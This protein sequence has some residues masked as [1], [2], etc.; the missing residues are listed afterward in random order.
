VAIGVADCLTGIAFCYALP[1][2]KT[3]APSRAINLLKRFEPRNRKH[4]R[5]WLARRHATSTGVW[6]VYRKN[7][8]RQITY[9]EAVEEALCFGWIDSV[10]RPIDETKYMQLFTPR[11]AKSTWSRINKGRIEKL[12]KAGLM[13][14]AGEA[15][16]AIA[17]K[18]GSW[19]SID[20]V[21]A[22]VIPEDLAAAIAANRNATENF[23]KLSPSTRRIYL[24]YINNAKRP[25]TR[26]RHLA[27]VVAL[28]AERTTLP[29]QG[30]RPQPQR[31]EQRRRRKT[32]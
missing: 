15:A 8:R 4:W 31:G 16:I 3:A 18:N 22:M 13:H 25:E 20:H 1:M 27:R 26:A 14:P 6:L 12:A 5:E 11:K 21:E 2:A 19:V 24:H 30:P 9:A 28:I 10:Y 17:R 7:P 23:P 29:R 32:S